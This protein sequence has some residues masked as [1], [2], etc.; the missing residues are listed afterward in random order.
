MYL[1]LNNQDP[2]HAYLVESMLLG[3]LHKLD[4]RH[5]SKLNSLFLRIYIS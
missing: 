1:I 3:G 5:K 4:L 2:M